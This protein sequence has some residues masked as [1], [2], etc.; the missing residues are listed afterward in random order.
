[1]LRLIVVFFAFL[2]LAP[3]V[4]GAEPSGPKLILYLIIDEL[5]NEQLL[6]LQP[7][8]TKD[9]FNRISSQ[10]M[11]LMSA[12]S[13]DLSGYPGTRLTSFYTGTTPSVHGIVGEQWYDKKINHYVEAATPHFGNLHNTLLYNQAQSISDYL[14]SFY[15][16]GVRS[17]A[18]TIQAPWMLHTVGY[19]PD[20][21]F[22]FNTTYGTFVDQIAPLAFET[23]WLQRFNENLLRS[24][25]RQ[26]Q[27]GPLNDITTYT[28]YQYL[29]PAEQNDFRSFLYN[30]NV[31]EGQPFEPFAASPY[32]NTLVRDLAVSFIAGTDFARNGTPDVLS[33]TF[34]ARPFQSNGSILPAEKEDML[35]R[36]DRDIA[37]LISFLDNEL[38]R[39]QYLV[40]LT[41]A[42]TS[43]PDHSTSGKK[44]VTT[45]VVEFKKISALLNL[46]LM[47]IH[48]QGKWV[49]GMHDNMV[50][51][52]HQ[53][54][55]ER[56]MAIDEMQ[57]LAARFL[58]DVAGIDRAIPTY[59][60]VFDIETPTLLSNNIYPSRSG[61]ILLS[62]Q[63]GWQS[64]VTPAGTR[65]TGHS[66]HTPI[67]LTLRGWQVT[68]GAWFE[69]LEH[70]YITPLILKQLGIIH[71][72]IL[73]APLVP[74]F[75][76]L[77]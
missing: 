72:S 44:G 39:D 59:H 12:Y 22:S 8:L 54:I 52:N 56:G 10:G 60:L 36:L 74:V 40:V 6:L 64:A 43:A 51:L 48:G 23:Q 14:K 37:S 19:A 29:P 1:M 46:Y 62:L 76:P 58:M 49:L 65:Q 5:N 24:E 4:K 7:K 27:W 30:M 61:D 77:P 15:G 57:Q 21:F 53:L 47:A 42:A 11:R 69:P 67:P 18:I 17:A 71:P 28:E 70:H 32:A 73:K 50:Y 16:P 33:L 63:S 66:G 41:A 3:K 35:L 38:G 34:T 45:G 31:R 75:K 55:T 20:H 9:G 68:P 13:A 26:R 2:L 25:L